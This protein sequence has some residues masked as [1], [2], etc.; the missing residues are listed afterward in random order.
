MR[1]DSRVSCRLEAGPSFA[2]LPISIRLLL[3]ASALATASTASAQDRTRPVLLSTSPPNAARGVDPSSSVLFVFDEPMKPQQRITWISSPVAIGSNDVVYAWNSAGTELTAS[4]RTGWPTNQ[5]ILWL[6]QPAMPAIPGVSPAIPGFEDLA[7]NRLSAGAGS[8]ITSAGGPPPW[9]RS[10]NSCGLVSSNLLRTTLRIAFSAHH[11]QT[12][13]SPP[14]PSVLVGSQPFA[15]EASL[16]PGTGS[17]SSAVLLTP[18]ETTPALTLTPG[19]DRFAR[20]DIFASWAALRA[21]FPHGAY[22]CVATGAVGDVPARTTSTVPEFDPPVLRVANHEFLQG[23]LETNSL[24]ILWD[25]VPGTTNDVIRIRVSPLANP[26]VTLWSSPDPGCPGALD[27][28]ATAAEIPVAPLGS[29]TLFHAE[30]R[31]ERRRADDGSPTTA[32]TLIEW[33]STTRVRVVLCRND[34]RPMRERD[35]SGIPDRCDDLLSG[36]STNGL[37]F[38]TPPVLDSGHVRLRIGPTEI[39]ATYQLFHWSAEPVVDSGGRRRPRGGPVDTPVGSPVVATETETEFQLPFE[40][41]LRGRFFGVA[42]TGG[43]R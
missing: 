6:F 28:T 12:N 22:S 24:P 40:P 26:N 25:P 16:V 18:S 5:N 36:S 1:S 33:T 32:R 39:G 13:D 20:R 14:A 9:I 23:T 31:F 7:G 8:F 4:N 19:S 37:R 27:G 43:R 17:A 21:A 2:R 29:G 38:R 42:R 34:G 10:T 30:L 15:V 3:L 35:P 41:A 11:T